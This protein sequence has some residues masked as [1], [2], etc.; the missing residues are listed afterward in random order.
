MAAM[1]KE[2]HRSTARRQIS[3]RRVPK[4]H[5]NRDVQLNGLDIRQGIRRGENNRRNSPDRRNES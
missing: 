5:R 2:E 3:D 1:S 4:D